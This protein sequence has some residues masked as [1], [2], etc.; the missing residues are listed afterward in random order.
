MA[1]YYLE[2]GW[3][4]PQQ[5]SQISLEIANTDSGM[6]TL[7]SDLAVIRNVGK[8]ELEAELDEVINKFMRDKVPGFD[9][10]NKRIKSQWN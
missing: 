8:P 3:Y 10:L 2:L 4:T 6:A 1:K 5:L 9:T 7:L